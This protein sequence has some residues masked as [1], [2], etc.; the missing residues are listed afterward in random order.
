MIYLHIGYPKTGTTTIQSGLLDNRPLLEQYGYYYP[1]SGIFIH[2]HHNIYYELAAKDRTV[3]KLSNRFVSENGSLSDLVAELSKFKEM[4]SMAN[5]IIS[6]EAYFTLKEPYF[7]EL[8]ERL[9]EVDDITAVS[10]T[11]LTLPTTPYV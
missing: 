4:D 2:G 3:E 5:F 1:R 11:H 6:S 10:Y 8:I 7:K 9:N